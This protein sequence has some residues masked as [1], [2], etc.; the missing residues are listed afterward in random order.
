ML[1]GRLHGLIKIGWCAR[2]NGQD[3]LP[4]FDKSR[5]QIGGDAC[6]SCYDTEEFSER[7]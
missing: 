4:A 1:A 6:F 3:G 5:G 2:L 7:L